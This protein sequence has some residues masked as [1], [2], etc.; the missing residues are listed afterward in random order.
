MKNGIELKKL[1]PPPNEGGQKLKRTNHKM[2]Q[3]LIPEQPKKL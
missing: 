1:P 2:L 3:R